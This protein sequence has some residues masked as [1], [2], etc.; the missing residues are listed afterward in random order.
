MK[1]FAEKG[2][3][4]AFKGQGDGGGDGPVGGDDAEGRQG[5]EGQKRR[6]FQRG[7]MAGIPGT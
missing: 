4:V 5:G 7:S 2:C 6:S 3:Q 1:T